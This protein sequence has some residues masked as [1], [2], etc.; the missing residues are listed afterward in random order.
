MPFS[1]LSRRSF[2][3]LA[4]SSAA[5]AALPI[6]LLS[7]AAA[8]GRGN[9]APVLARIHGLDGSIEQA[10]KFQ[11]FMMDAYASGS[12][13]RLIQSYSDGGLQST[14][15]TYD[16]AVSIHGYL[17]AGGDDSLERASI[18]GE[19]LLYAQRTNFPVADG[20]FAQAYFV[21]LPASDGSGAY[22]TPA[23][24]P[25][26]FYTSAVGDQAWAGMALAKLY[27][28]TGNQAFL[29]G[30]LWVANW[31]VNNTYSVSGAGGFSFG[32]NINQYNQS[33][34]SGNGKSTEHNIDSYAFF[35]MLDGLTEGGSANSGMTWATLAGHART[36][37]TAMYNAKGPFFWTGTQPNGVDINYY[38]V[39]EDCQTWSYLALL[40]ANLGRTIDWA[41]ANLETTDTASAQHSSLTGTQQIHGLVF[42]TASLNSGADDQHAVW[43]EG[44][45]HGITALIARI[46]H[47]GVRGRQMVADVAQAIDLLNN[48]MLAQQELGVGQ[49]VAGKLIPAG[50]GLVAATSIMDTGFGYT[51][52]PSLHIGATG[53]YLI[54]NHA[55]NPFR[56]ADSEDAGRF[57]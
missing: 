14:S 53:W 7:R 33:V 6:S 24:F 46:V 22:I 18:L 17:A 25:F 35:T 23:A 15:F 19:G 20:R 48:C 49:T 16:N 13:V 1:N 9:G 29:T 52:G 27:A 36:F 47:G 2:F 26:Y 11:N 44:T 50:S 40:D 45:S 12:T 34:P 54:A 8:E 10:L 57:D 31:I 21:N 43:M 3:G 28:R 5:A 37:L 30:A 32:E 38:P 55:A 39:P 41:T 51:Y 56:L 42:D 4:S